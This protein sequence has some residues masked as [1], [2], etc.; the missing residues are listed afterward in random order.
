MLSI[1]PK[2]SNNVKAVNYK[3]VDAKTFRDVARFA[4]QFQWSPIQFKNN[5]RKKANYDCAVYCVLDIDEGLSLID[6]QKILKNK[7]IKSIILSTQNHQ[8]PKNGKTC[9]RYRIIM[10]WDRV[11]RDLNDYEF[12]YRLWNRIFGG[13]KN[14]EEGARHFKASLSYLGHTDGELLAVLKAPPKRQINK[15]AVYEKIEFKKSGQLPCH[16][17]DF[18]ERGIL[19]GTGRQ[20]S[21]FKAACSLR[22]LGLSQA[23]AISVLKRAPINISNFE[24]EKEFHHA[25]S[26]AYRY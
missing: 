7:N 10:R 26:S 25:V 16:V 8:K 9:D 1:Y 18:I 20:E 24:F 11:I 13:D 5:Y 23:Q 21:F 15:F 14:T 19:I 4:L 2:S 12:N 6:A 17:T 3:R 22:N